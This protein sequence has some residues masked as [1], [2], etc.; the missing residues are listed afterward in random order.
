LQHFT[1]LDIQGLDALGLHTT[2]GITVA[3]PSA[4][5]TIHRNSLGAVHHFHN[6]VIVPSI[7]IMI[8]FWRQ[9]TFM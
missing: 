7:E 2:T 6:V 9:I 5:V 8:E 4:G 1:A 3:P